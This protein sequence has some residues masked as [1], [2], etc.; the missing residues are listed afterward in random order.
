MD[1]SRS[2]CL[3]NHVLFSG[4]ARSFWVKIQTHWG[5]TVPH[6]CKSKVMTEGTWWGGNTRIILM[7]PKEKLLRN[8]LSSITGDCLKAWSGHSGF[9]VLQVTTIVPQYIL[10]VGD[11][12]VLIPRIVLPFPD[13]FFLFP[14]VVREEAMG[15]SPPSGWEEHSLICPWVISTNRNQT[16]VSISIP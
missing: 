4:K 8:A 10:Y 1:I 13:F 5:I 7:P 12:C 2:L 3:Q 11:W 14:S 9:I 16:P 15:L 6:H